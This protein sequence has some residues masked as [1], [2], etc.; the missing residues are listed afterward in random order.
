MQD[1]KKT[2]C[3]LPPYRRARGHCNWPTSNCCSQF[4]TAHLF[5][6]YPICH[7]L[8]MHSQRT[9]RRQVEAGASSKLPEAIAPSCG[10]AEPPANG[11]CT[12]HTR[13]SQT[14]ELA[15]HERRL[16]EKETDMQAVMIRPSPLLLGSPLMPD[17]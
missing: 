3:G 16:P 7:F 10:L 15:I 11:H 9:R 2:R 5:C 8:H 13:F 14:A 17:R 1:A 4:A 12:E 6:I